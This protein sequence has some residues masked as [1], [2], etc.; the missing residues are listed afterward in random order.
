M[1][2]DPNKLELE[3]KVVAIKR[4]AKVVKGGR[5][6]RFSALVVVGDRNGHVG[7]GLGKAGEVPDAIRKGIEAAKKNLIKVPIVK[8]TIPHEIIG[9]HGAGKV[10][11]KPA[12]KGTGVIAGGP[13]RA[14]LEL[15]GVQ[16][17]LTKSLGSSNAINMVRATFEGLQRLKT[18]EEVARLRGKTVEELLG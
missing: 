3:E 13:V 15:A 2:I 14:V 7:F 5:R 17:I 6:F 9:H 1:Q 12:S 18:A 8:S 10:L 4:V 16:D 11:M